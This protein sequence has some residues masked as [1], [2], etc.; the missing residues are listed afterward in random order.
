MNM[1]VSDGRLAA[2]HAE[3][4]KLHLCEFWSEIKALERVDPPEAWRPHVWRYEEIYPRLLQAA[5]I[6][7]LDQAERRA[8]VFRN[9]AFPER[10]ATTPTHYAAYSLYNG[11]EQ[12]SVHRHTANAVRIGLQGTG[13]YTTVERTKYLLDRGDLVLTPNWTWHDH[14]NDGHEPNVWFDILDVPLVV[15]TNCL[16]F[17]FDY[18]EQEGGEPR[19][20]RVQTPART[21][22]AKDLQFA[23]ASADPR[24]IG[25]G[26]P[27]FYPWA[28]TLEA[29]D[30]LMQLN[31]SAAAAEGVELRGG[32]GG[33][34]LD[35]I[36]L[37]AIR[38]G[39]GSATAERRTSAHTTVLVMAG[40]GFTEIDG[41]RY[42]WRENDVLYVPNWRWHRHANAD[43]A[44]PA[45]LY[46]MTD[47]PVMRSMRTLR[48]Q[49]RLPDGRIVP[50]TVAAA[51]GR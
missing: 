3:S 4:R 38:V 16:F 26:A 18:F 19:R 41:H 27:C 47:T 46:V 20:R 6:V 21:L 25:P 49:Q 7:P 9:P 10:I 23:G 34:A 30:R 37:R 42:D 12:A 11:G 13:G 29:L 2:L 35:T 15:H 40:R 48:T 50:E 31:G 44:H 8:V 33:S 14:G 22:G 17:D 39:P 28:A 1:N 36:D 45:L 5:D 43:P 24:S 32:D 51:P